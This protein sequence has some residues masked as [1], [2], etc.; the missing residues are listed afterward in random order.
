MIC[1]EYG[2][3]VGDQVIDVGREQGTF[4]NDKATKYPSQVGDSQNPLLGNGDLSTVTGKGLGVTSSN[5]FGNCCSC[6]V[7]FYHSDCI[8]S[9]FLFQGKRKFGYSKYQNWRT[10]NSYD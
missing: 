2:L 9:P 4:S 10:I 7:L 6:F 5:T 8:L 1:P 3:V